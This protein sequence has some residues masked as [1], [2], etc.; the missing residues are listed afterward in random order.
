MLNIM[1]IFSTA[2]PKSAAELGTD[3]DIDSHVEVRRF[4]K[5]ARGRVRWL[6]LCNDIPW[7]ALEMV[8]TVFPAAE[9]QSSYTHNNFMYLFTKLDK[10]ILV[11][12]IYLLG[13]EFFPLIYDMTTLHITFS[14]ATLFHAGLIPECTWIKYN[15]ISIQCFPLG[16]VL[17]N[18]PVHII[19]LACIAAKQLRIFKSLGFEMLLDYV[20]LY[21]LWKNSTF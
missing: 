12:S 17:L 10:L 8:S 7:V 19:A 3:I 16:N 2:I 21:I 13:T 11:Y 4:I 20:F 14:Y 1:L 5:E 18:K 15:G 6:G 9:M